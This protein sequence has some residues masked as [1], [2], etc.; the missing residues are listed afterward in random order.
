MFLMFNGYFFQKFTCGSFIRNFVHALAI[1]RAL[2]VK[3]QTMLEL[4]YYARD[5]STNSGMSRL[6]TYTKFNC[7]LK[8]GLYNVA[9]LVW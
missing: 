2:V 5:Y 7:G 4:H 6:G 1:V 8:D 3:L 9:V